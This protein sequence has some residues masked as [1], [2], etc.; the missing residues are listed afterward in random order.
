[1]LATPRGTVANELLRSVDQVLALEDVLLLPS[2]GSTA[3]DAGTIGSA[4]AAV[5]DEQDISALILLVHR[6]EDRLDFVGVGYLIGKAMAQNS[7]G[8]EDSRLR[9]LLFNRLADDG[10]VEVYKM[11]NKDAGADPVSAC[12][13]N[14]DHARVKEVLA[15]DEDDDFADND[16]LGD[17]T[18][19][20]G[21]SD[22]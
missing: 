22:E 2:T 18:A 4:G 6:L 8:P 14:Y 16:D 7:V 20:E 21:D 17:G 19:E 3:V 10:I 15:R 9:R 12:R 1:V 5:V 13:L 11:D